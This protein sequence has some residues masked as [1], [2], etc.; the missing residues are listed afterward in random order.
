MP[1]FDL[2]RLHDE[3]F[4]AVM[5][6][7][8]VQDIVTRAYACVGRP[9]IAF[10]VTF[11]LLAFAF[12]RP[13]PFDKWEQIASEGRL[14][15]DVIDETQS[16]TYQEMMYSSGRSQVFDWGTTADYHQVC[17]PVMQGGSLVGYVGIGIEDERDTAALLE[18][19]DL[20]ADVLAISLRDA[21]QAANSR[22]SRRRAAEELLLNE[23]ISGDAALRLADAYPPP[24][25]FAVLSAGDARVSTL[26]YVR[27]LLCT[28]E[29]FALGALDENRYLYLLF[30]QV[31]QDIDLASARV[32]LSE[33]AAKYDFRGGIS[34]YFRDAAALAAHREQ[35][36]LALRT[37]PEA[38]GGVASFRE[39]YGAVVCRAARERLG[40][41]ACALPGVQRLAELDAREG[42]EYLRTLRVYLEVFQ[43][44]T[45]AAARL[46]VHKNTVLYR[47]RRVGELLD[48]DLSGA[49]HPM[50]LELGLEMA[51]TDGGEGARA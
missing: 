11:R 33:V 16:L 46:G 32:L 2:D 9:I 47:I 10:D 41:A 7:Q 25:L 28:D 50:E 4:D 15:A 20:L 19:N 39:R 30:F 18:A 42:T 49:E 51:G 1:G 3:L 12:P 31:G 43:N 24:Y 5:R 44:S 8:S 13:C 22:E 26:Q 35:A 27:G 48:L 38:S 34:D 21:A 37:G 29:N 36:L 45:D 14:S 40:P 6:K 17:G 23:N